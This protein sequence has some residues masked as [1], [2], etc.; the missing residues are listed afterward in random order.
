[1]AQPPIA[2]HVNNNVTAK[3]LAEI[4]GQ[5]HDLRDGFR[6][7]AV[8][9]KDRDLEH[10][11]DIGGISAGTG[12][13]G[14]SGETNLIIDNHMNRPAHRITGQLA[15]VQGFL[16]HALAGKTGV[17]MDEQRQAVAA[18]RATPGLEAILLDAGAPEHHRVCLLYTSP[19]PRDRQK[20]RMPS[21]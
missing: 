17:A 2:K 5:P 16:H 4:H 7:F 10:P 11:S 18:L 6:V 21:S 9:V 8:D 15:Q 13:A 14:R 12:L 20:S 3:S 19:S 1:M